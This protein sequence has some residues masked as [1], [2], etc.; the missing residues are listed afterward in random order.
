MGV[1]QRIRGRIINFHSNELRYSAKYLNYIGLSNFKAAEIGVS[2]GYNAVYLLK[3]TK[4]GSLFLID[5]FIA[6][7]D[8]ECPFL[9]EGIQYKEQIKTQETMDSSYL[10]LLSNIEPYK[11]RVTV[12][13]KTSVDAARDYPD[14]YFDYVYIDGCHN[15]ESVSLDM[16]TWYPKVAAGGVFAGHDYPLYKG[17]TKAVDTFVSKI[18]LILFASNG[19]WCIFKK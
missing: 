10:E 5:P 15:E 6:Y 18:G 1:E 11:D 7:V 3:E 19:D 8:K 12:V 17:V 14:G 16:D 9:I 13:R 2:V 4:V